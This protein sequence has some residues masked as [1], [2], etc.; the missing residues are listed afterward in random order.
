[1]QGIS[2][3]IEQVKKCGGV[4]RLCVLLFILAAIFMAGCESKK[5]I[6]L[7]EGGQWA[8]RSAEEVCPIL[9]GAAVPELTLRTVDGKSF[10]LNEAIGNKP[11]VLIFYRLFSFN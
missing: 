9:V 7:E 6:T 2:D 1:M 10:D 4:I 8:G 5:D 11:T 3:K